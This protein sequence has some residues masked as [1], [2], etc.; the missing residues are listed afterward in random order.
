MCV[1]VTARVFVKFFT[2][3]RLQSL[4]NVFSRGTRTAVG[5]LDVQYNIVATA[6]AAVQFGIDRFT[7]IAVAQYVNPGE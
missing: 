1:C 3:F 2:L 7:H 4:I 6:T 5:A